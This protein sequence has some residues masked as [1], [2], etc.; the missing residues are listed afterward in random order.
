[1]RGPRTG[2]PEWPRDTERLG[3][4][5]VLPSSHLKRQAVPS[6]RSVSAVSPESLCSFSVTIICRKPALHTQPRNGKNLK[7]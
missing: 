2:L 5:Q 4:L 6:L 3:T 7:F 1:M